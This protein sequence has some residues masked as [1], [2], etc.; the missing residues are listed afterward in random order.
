FVTATVDPQ[1]G[2]PAVEAWYSKVTGRV[3]EIESH[4]THARMMLPEHVSD[5]V[6]AI[7]VSPGEPAS[8]TRQEK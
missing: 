6:H 2:A 3:V 7:G 1:P 8:A 4:S 5:W